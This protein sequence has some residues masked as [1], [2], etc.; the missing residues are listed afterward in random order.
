MDRVLGSNRQFVE[1]EVPYLPDRL[2][3]DLREVIEASEVIVIAN[4]APEYR[5]VGP[6]LKRGQALV[7]LVHVVDPASVTHGEYHGLAW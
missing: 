3:S 1:D 2:R 5:T 6:L 4:G 7:D